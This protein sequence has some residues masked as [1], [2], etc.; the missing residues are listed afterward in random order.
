MEHAEF[1]PV[2]GDTIVSSEY[3]HQK[4]RNKITLTNIFFQYGILSPVPGII[5]YCIIY[6]CPGVGERVSGTSS[7]VFGANYDISRYFSC[8]PSLTLNHIPRGGVNYPYSTLA[9][10]RTSSASVALIRSGELKF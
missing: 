3:F 1:E 5:D 6:R 9:I 7:A 8:Y 2:S 4:L 10:K